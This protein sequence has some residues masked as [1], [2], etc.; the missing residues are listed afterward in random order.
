MIQWIDKKF[1]NWGEWLQNNRGIGSRGLSACWGS[2]GGGGHATSIVPVAS[3]DCSRTHDWVMSLSPEQQRI[4]VE[5]YCTPHTAVQN[6]RVLQM[7][8]RTLYA[9][10][11][12]IQSS[13]AARPRPDRIPLAK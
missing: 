13:Y 3:I 4:L 5:V 6:A 7:S 12:E 1:L 8:L 11:H 10:L 9:R 2:V